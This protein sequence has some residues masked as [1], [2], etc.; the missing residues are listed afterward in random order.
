MKK[1]IREQLILTGMGCFLCTG[2]VVIV[3]V[4]LLPYVREWY[5]YNALVLMVCTAAALAAFWLA[6]RAIRKADEAKLARIRRIAVPA[7][8]AA[9][10][11]VQIVLG[12]MME[13]TPMGDNF[14]LYNGSQLYA[15]EG[16]FE[17]YPDFGLYLARFS[18]QWGAVM[19]LI[20]FWKLLSLVGITATFMPLVVTQAAL[21]TLGLHSAFSIVRRVRGARGEV[22]LL[23]LL[24]F[25]FPLYLA[26]G[27]LYTDTF[28]APF[29]LITLDWAMRAAQEENRKKQVFDALICAAA[30][31]L[32]AQIKMTV[33]IVLIAAVIVWALCMKPVRALLCCG[34]CMLMIALGMTGMQKAALSTFIDPALYAQHH[35]P[36]IHWVIMS[37]PRGD[38]PFGSYS[39]I[40]YGIT[41]TIQ[42][43]GATR[44]EVMDSIY[45]RL[46]DR[47]YT[48]RYPNR[49]ITGMLRKNAVSFGDGSFGMTEMLDDGPVR[50]NAVSQIV[51]EGRPY[52]NAYSVV[53]TGIFMAH[54]ALAVWGCLSN[55][56]Q[57]DTRMAIPAVAFFGI[58]FFL[59]LWEARARYLFGF[60]PV[61]M[62][63]A[64][65]GAV[66]D[67]GGQR[68]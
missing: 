48:L 64:A 33:L 4:L 13:Y 30:A 27:V 23:V 19:M 26:A 50:E 59:L 60:A 49:L 41:W 28:S 8:L 63:L 31:L 17:S 14:M 56:K 40:D 25:F 53:C 20:G 36:A 10:F 62:L 58:L 16:S 1:E 67:E 2:A 21:Y 24:I 11:V 6:A 39:S 29:V 42:E 65:A 18:N 54:M 66:R 44:E 57:R 3:N 52:Y 45:T 47:I 9:L 34:L 37:I 7:Y 32:G 55:I 43:N 61:L 5:G 12:Y 51:L 22:M 35:T 46:I 38:N 15:A 68:A